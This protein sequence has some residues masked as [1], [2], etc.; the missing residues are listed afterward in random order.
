MVEMI[1][2]GRKRYRVQFQEILIKKITV[3]ILQ[4][5]VLMND[6]HLRNLEWDQMEFLI[7]IYRVRKLNNNKNKVRALANK[8]NF[9]LLEVKNEI[10]INLI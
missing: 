8:I 7:L 3:K 1:R 5:I 2:E 10:L 9:L 4:R 6:L